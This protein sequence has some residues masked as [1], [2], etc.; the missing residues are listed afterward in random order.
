VEFVGASHASLSSAASSPQTVERLARA[1][2]L[3]TTKNPVNYFQVGIETA[4]PKLIGK[5]MRG[6]VYPFRPEQWPEV[7]RDG[8]RIYHDN[9]FVCCA[10]IILG[11]P[12]EER[13]DVEQTTA[14]IRS[15]RPYQ[16]LI[17]PLFF[18]PLQTT[19]L[20]HAGP[21]LKRDLTPQHYELITACWDHNFAWFPPIWVHYGRDKNV[22]LRTVMRLL[23]THGTKLVRWRMHRDAR[24]HGAKV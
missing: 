12:G 11:L 21:L 17:V 1:L 10:T 19:R 4:S 13:E 6:K 22:V 24:K 23:L 2:E 14:L 20:E 9:N 7:V 8:F 18:T 16:S 15:L 3:G 5:H